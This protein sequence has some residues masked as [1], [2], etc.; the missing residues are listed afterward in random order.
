MKAFVQRN[1]KLNIKHLDKDTFLNLK[2]ILVETK[3]DLKITASHDI[4]NI[5]TLIFI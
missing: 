3:I 4:V 2:M 1:V 5:F